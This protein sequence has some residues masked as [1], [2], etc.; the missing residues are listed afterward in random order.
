MMKRWLPSF[1]LFAC[2]AVPALRA[3]ELPARPENLQQVLDRLAPGDT[4]VLAPGVYYG[5]FTLNK[6]GEKDLPIT[7]RADRTERGR[8]V[9]TCADRTLREGKSR[10]KLEDRE[11]GLYSVPFDHNPVRVLYSGTDLMPYSTLDGLKNFTLLTGCPGPEHGF[12]YEPAEK[13]LYV[14]LHA[15]K[16][17]SPDP[18]RHLIAAAPVTSP[19]YNGEKITRPEHAN[20]TILPRGEG[21]IVID[22]I[23]FETPG[24]AAV[25]TYA[26]DVVV[27]NAWFNGCRFGVFGGGKR[28]EL[29]A[30]VTIEHT[31]YHHTP[32]FEDVADLIAKYAKTPVY[33]K[34]SIF[35]WHRK[36][37]YGNY[38]VMKNYETGIAG[39]IGRE[40]II[41]RNLISDAFEGLSTWG[42]SWSS[43]LLVTENVF[44]NIVDNALEAEN[45][46]AN[47]TIRHNVFKNCFEAISWQPL[48]GKP[49]P[50]PVF[51]YDNLFYTTPEFR[52][53]WPW[54]PSV[55]KIGASDCNWTKKHMGSVKENEP[56]G[57]E[58]KRFAYS[59]GVGFLAFNNTIFHEH[60]NFFNKPGPLER[61]LVNFR[62]FN[63]II[64]TAAFHKNPKYRGSLIEFYNNL[65]VSPGNAEQSA[66][67]AGAGGKVLDS[68]EALRLKAPADYDFTPLADSPVRGA[69]TTAIHPE[70]HAD[71]GAIPVGGTWTMPR[72]GPLTAE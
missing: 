48:D 70:S 31:L 7:I 46:A 6:T 59:P 34:Y 27:R 47:M 4:A 11:T 63:N 57:P 23:T 22:G 5:P 9:L 17:G 62:F 72:V 30:R 65:V 36:G 43:G 51:V 55:F 64:V 45:H 37:S 29:P 42:N 25:L 71:I 52:A 8:V 3:A 26:S 10:W 49:W 19:G 33:G 58:S 32:A 1:F 41:R 15:T 21:Y 67:L 24:A 60:G 28:E 12:F 56:R 2:L 69:G 20:L 68:V 44:E 38:D 53:I 54:R 50:G 40:W 13:K 18:N 35:W 14:R 61:E 39:G 16:Y 66:L